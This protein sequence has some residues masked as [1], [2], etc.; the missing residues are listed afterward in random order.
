MGV[1]SALMRILRPL[2]S[3]LLALSVLAGQWLV[4]DH[5]HDRSVATASEHACAI[6]VYAH[7]AGSGALPV[8]PALH[9]EFTTVVQE[10]AAAVSRA[11][12]PQQHHPIRGP[13][14]IL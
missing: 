1:E 10:F 11:S 12:A 5:D 2:V 13:P 3:L 6:C 8:A 7:A 14:Q 4:V 9:F